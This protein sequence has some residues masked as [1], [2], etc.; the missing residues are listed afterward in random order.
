MSMT[1]RRR[2]ALGQG[3]S[4]YPLDVSFA[5]GVKLVGYN[6]E[7]DAVRLGEQNRD[8]RLTLFWET[9]GASNPA[10]KEL[11]YRQTH[12]AAIW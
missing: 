7:P 3:R 11:T 4:K 6:V 5:N 10:S 12:H 9:A 8:F 1:R 2:R